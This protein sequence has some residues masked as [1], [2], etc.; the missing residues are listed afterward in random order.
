M[1]QTLSQKYSDP[2]YWQVVTALALL[3]EPAGFYG[4]DVLSVTR[5][6]WYDSY[7]AARYPWAPSGS[8]SKS[9]LAL[10]IHD[11]FQP[12]SYWNG[13]MSEPTFEDV[14]LDTHNYQVFDPSY[15]SWSYD[16]HVQVRFTKLECERILTNQGIC[17][18]ASAYSQSP[19][20]LVV[21]EWSLATTDCAYW[22]NGRGV[23][24]RYE[25]SYPGSN[26]VGSCNGKSGD[27]SNFSQ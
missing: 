16:T 23:G 18:Q 13:F 15:Q 1:I 6:Y 5:Q 4:A 25:G 21:G 8:A 17:N 12:L 20:W 14:F 19:L 3:N 10:V 2:S 22:L 11:A 26:Y 7:G 24:V 9:G 27:G